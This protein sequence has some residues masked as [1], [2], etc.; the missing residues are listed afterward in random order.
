VKQ[1]KQAR[2]QKDNTYKTYKNILLH[3][4]LFYSEYR[5]TK[6]NDKSE[7]H[8]MKSGNITVADLKRV[9]GYF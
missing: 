8:Y 9:G 2:Q 6:N 3:I 7:P 5:I 4:G 1:A